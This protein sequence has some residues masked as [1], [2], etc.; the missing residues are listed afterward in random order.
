MEWTKRGNTVDDEAILWK[1]FKEGSEAAF[2]AIYTRYFKILYNYASK[3]T[4]DK[5]L[6]Q[7]CIHDLFIELWEKR[8]NLSDTTSIKYYLFK[9]MR[10]TLLDQLKAKPW[11]V[12]NDPISGGFDFVPPY[13]THL[14]AEQL[15]DE[16]T[17]RILKAL[18]TLT[19][20]QK[21]AIFLKFY[22]NL[23]YDE[24]ASIMSMNIDSSYNLISKALSVLR[25]NIT[26][27]SLV[28]LFIDSSI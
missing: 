19:Q 17:E 2:E 14:I 3:F 27:I 1:T 9:A 16:Q 15:S 24:I 21:E 7:D 22:N 20:R 18:N 6:V 26:P 23:S 4:P 25:K 8:E 28:L 13:E 12:E 11:L 5:N 10:Y